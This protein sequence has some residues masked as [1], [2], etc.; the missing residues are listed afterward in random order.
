LTADRTRTPCPTAY[1]TIVPL[2]LWALHFV[3]RDRG[4]VSES[5]DDIVLLGAVASGAYCAYHALAGRPIVRV[6]FTFAYALCK[7]AR[8]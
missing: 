2:L 5:L 4:L 7:S 8:L 1:A 3:T 6:G